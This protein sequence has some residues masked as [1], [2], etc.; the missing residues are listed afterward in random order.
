MFEI[1][2]SLEH[3]FQNTN[4]RIQSKWSCHKHDT[5]WYVTTYGMSLLAQF[6]STSFP[7]FC[8]PKMLCICDPYQSHVGV[9]S[10]ETH[11]MWGLSGYSY[12]ISWAPPVGIHLDPVT[13]L[14][15]VQ[16]G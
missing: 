14:V 5:A 15:L 3:P 6:S 13:G 1:R 2:H 8:N 16:T 9:Q 7:V 10:Y 12:G 4:I 11:Y